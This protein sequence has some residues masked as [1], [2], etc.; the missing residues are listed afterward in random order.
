MAHAN[1]NTVELLGTYGGDISHAMSAWTST[2]RDIDVP[3]PKTGKTKRERIQSLLTMLATS[4]HETPFEKSALHFLCTTEI[5]SHIHLLKHRIGV[6]ING[7]C[8]HGD[9]LITFVDINGA[10]SPKMKVPI[11]KLYKQWTTGRKHQNTQADML[12]QR[13]RIQARRIRVLN[14]ETGEFETSHI[15]DIM[16]SG[17]KK[18]YTITLE[19]GKSL[20]CSENHRV[21]TSNGWATLS[22][23]TL[24]EGIYVATNGISS[25]VDG[26]PWTFPEF[27]NGSI[28]YTRKE[29]AKKQNI[30]Y[31]LCKKW[32]YIFNVKFAIDENGSFPKN[33]VPWNKNVKGYKLDLSE[34][35][36]AI[37]SEQGKKF[38]GENSNFW[39]GGVCPE[40]ALIGA[41]TTKQA[42]AVH[43]KYNWTCQVCSSGK[44]LHAH[45]IVPVSYDAKLAYSFDN[46]V[47]VCMKCHNKIHANEQS[48][49]NSMTY[50]LGESF[51]QRDKVVTPRKRYSVEY[52][53]IKSIVDAG[54]VETYDIEI[55][56]QWKN[57]VADGCVVHNS[58]RY[59]E[60][61]D[62]KFFVPSD[63]SVSQRDDYQKFMVNAFAAYHRALK[64]VEADLIAKGVDK[65]TARSRAKESARFYLPYGNQLVCD[66]QFNFRS[67]YHFLKL[68]YAMDA[69]KE[70]RDIARLMLE[71]VHAQGDFDKTLIAFGLLDEETNV[72][73][74][75]F[76]KY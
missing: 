18:V 65:K 68:R 69:Q 17:K 14:E 21:F 25:H 75:P 44:K 43:A 32:G 50:F 41:W 16:S 11:E 61:K 6:S 76:E 12:Y 51:I 24:K 59:L 49:R 13:K 28:N 5:A 46:L 63:W 54:E 74:G 47:S 52:S 3:N 2:T 20:T 56:G 19:N 35:A 58:G 72:L 48:E 40:R 39:R 31:E 4:G 53:R 26:R 34:Q 66:V 57:F 62:D 33:S 30:K 42:P 37:R 73:R 55:A 7:E 15:K 60:L 29:F 1:K 10:S 9:S 71:Q 64:N 45:H 8:L 36:L 38:R 23:K 67:F 22:D 27:F 70:I